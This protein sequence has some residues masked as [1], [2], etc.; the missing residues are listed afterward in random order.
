MSKTIN[1]TGQF[2]MAVFDQ[3]SMAIYNRSILPLHIHID[4]SVVCEI[5]RMD[6]K[7]L[8]IFFTQRTDIVGS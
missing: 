2:S 4:N 7:K 5:H 3:F 8:Q 6:V 1:I